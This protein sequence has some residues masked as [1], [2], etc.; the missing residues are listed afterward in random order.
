MVLSWMEIASIVSEISS[1]SLCS[2]VVWLI[3]IRGSHSICN[4][5]SQLICN[6]GGTR[7]S[8]LIC[9]RG[10]SL[11]CNRGRSRKL[12]N[13]INVLME[14]AQSHWRAFWNLNR[15]LTS[16]KHGSMASR[17][18]RRWGFRVKINY[19]F[20]V[21]LCFLFFC[22]FSDSI[23][24]TFDPGYRRDHFIYFLLYVWVWFP[25][26]R[27]LLLNNIVAVV[28]SMYEAAYTFLMPL[29]IAIMVGIWIRVVLKGCKYGV[30]SSSGRS[31]LLH[32]VVLLEFFN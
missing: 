13:C 6:R 31:C 11:I 29:R 3:C 23:D 22:I 15:I 14:A 27:A 1:W 21:L 24:H 9:N 8:H 32:A 7:G 28:V 26:L 18:C 2:V 20:C 12:L 4:R 30:I 17:C 5:G 25:S 10:R 19:R 16:A